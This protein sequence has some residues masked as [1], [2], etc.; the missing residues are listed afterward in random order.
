M[1]Q[2]DEGDDA[3]R[4]AVNRN[5]ETGKRIGMGNKNGNWK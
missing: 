4:W 3:T 2:K 1:G 5:Q